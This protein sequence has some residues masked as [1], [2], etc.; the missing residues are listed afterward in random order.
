VAIDKKNLA[1]LLLV[2]LTV[3]NVAALVT[4]GY[5]RLRFERHF[6]PADASDEP[7]K[8]I[9]QELGLSQEQAKEFEANFEKFRAETKPITDSLEA[10][11][12]EMM[13]EVSADR[14]SMEKV[15]ELAGEIGAL[16]AQLQ[17]KMALHLLEGKSLLTPQQQK[18]FFSLFREGPGRA[19]GLREPG[20]MGG[21][22]RRPD[23]GESR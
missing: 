13:N 17:K 10:K 18:K 4:F 8:A 1:I 20:A 21:P 7:G 19:K 3:V 22:P 9:R 2:L 6:H 16:Q 15:D 5:H 23:F 11:K 12:A 14:P